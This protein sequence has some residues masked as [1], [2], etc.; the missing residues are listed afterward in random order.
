MGIVLLQFGLVGLNL[1]GAKN[2]KDNGRNPAFSYFVAGMC[3]GLGITRLI[4]ETDSDI[5]SV[6]N[7]PGETDE[8]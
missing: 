3:F 8:K 7:H 2:H 5:R 1:Y 4:R 6:V